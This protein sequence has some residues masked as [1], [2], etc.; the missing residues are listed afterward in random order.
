VAAPST[1]FD[2]K[3]PDGSAIPVEERAETEVLGD[4]LPGVRGWNPAFDVT[5]HHLITAWITEAGV[6]TPPFALLRQG[7]SSGA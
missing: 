5:P 4:A 3:T 1:T 6:L 7:G 2:F